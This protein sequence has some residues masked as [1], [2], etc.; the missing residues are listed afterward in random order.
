MVGKLSIITELFQ[1]LL[2][3]KKY[4]LMPVIIILTLLAILVFLAEYQAIAPFIY[5]I[6]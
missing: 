1:Y 4:F 5:A 2:M 3:R 6:F